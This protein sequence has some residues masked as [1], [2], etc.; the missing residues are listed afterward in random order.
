MSCS[1]RHD[2]AETAK[3]AAL[4]KELPSALPIDAG[5]RLSNP[6]R[7]VVHHSP[8]RKDDRESVNDEGRVEVL[9]IPRAQH[10]GGNQN[11]SPKRRIGTG[12]NLVGRPNHP[13][14][15]FCLQLILSRQEHSSVRP[16]KKAS[17]CG[18][19]KKTWPNNSQPVA[20]YA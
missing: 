14:R 2:L 1:Q 8:C 17:D 3:H 16:P 7:V 4:S 19:Q 10:D 12:P 6:N 18:Q 13:G 5:W 11:A 20:K 15:K 9:Q